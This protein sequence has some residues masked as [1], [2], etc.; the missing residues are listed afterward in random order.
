MS[1]ICRTLTPWRWLVEAE[2]YVGVIDLLVRIQCVCWF[3][4]FRLYIYICF[5][6]SFVQVYYLICHIVSCCVSV[7]AQTA[8]CVPVGSP[9][10]E[11]VTQSLRGWTV[12]AGSFV[13]EKMAL[14]ERLGEESRA[15]AFLDRSADSSLPYWHSWHCCCQVQYCQCLTVVVFCS[16]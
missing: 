11:V 10:L 13:A 16:R 9:H 2:T 15:V 14:F 4:Y 12:R 6:L 8:V 7:N 3:L 5:Y 1:S